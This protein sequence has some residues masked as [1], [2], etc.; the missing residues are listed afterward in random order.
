MHRTLGDIAHLLASGTAEVAIS[1]RMLSL[2]DASHLNLPEGREQSSQLCFERIH[3]LS[4]V[5]GAAVGMRLM[6]RA[7]NRS[8]LLLV[9][10]NLFL[11][12]LK[13]I[14]GAMDLIFY[15]VKVGFEALGL[16]PHLVPG[17]RSALFLAIDN[18]RGN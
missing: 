13:L 7:G 2:H 14:L 5:T 4:R 16:L 6:E 11:N 17:G 15:D 3:P 18:F 10:G 9:L 1:S 12:F 8:G